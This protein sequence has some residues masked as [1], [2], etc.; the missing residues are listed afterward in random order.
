MLENS[1]ATVSD[2]I[3]V[4]YATWPAQTLTPWVSV[5][6]IR[7]PKPGHD[8]FGSSALLTNSNPLAVRAEFPG[9]ASTVASNPT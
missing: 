4:R 6:S 3:S 2:G 8:P 9:Q 1:W 5:L 7:V